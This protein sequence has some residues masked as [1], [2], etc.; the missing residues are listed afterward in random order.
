[1][2]PVTVSV[3]K[4]ELKQQSQQELIE[5]C[6]HLVKFKKENKELLTYVLFE[7]EDEYE[8]IRSIKQE[9][10]SC[11]SELN[12]NSIYYIKKST[13]KILRLIK[14]YIRYSKKKETEAEILLYFCAKLKQ[15]KPSYK[16]SQ[17]MINMFEQQLKMASKAISFL[18]E[19]LQYDFNLEIEKLEE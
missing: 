8:Y 7:S 15:L 6:L 14:K 1:M 11:F 16:R 13:R 3:L 10:D 17:Q 12:I 4:K 2:K 9:I 19:D 5:I 18:H